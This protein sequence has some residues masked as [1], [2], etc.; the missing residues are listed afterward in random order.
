MTSLPPF[1]DNPWESPD[2]HIETL[3]NGTLLVDANRA[4]DS[5]YPHLVAMWQ[6]AVNRFGHRVYIAERNRDDSDWITLTY[7][8]ADVLSDS[9]AQWLLNKGLGQ[10]K[11]LLVLSAN[12]LEHAVL[13]LA[14]YK[15]RVPMAPVSPNYSLL[16][17]DHARV[18][19]I[20]GK[21]NPGA[22]F[23]QDTQAY[24]AAINA[25]PLENCELIYVDGNTDGANATPYSAL[26]D[27]A[28][29][30]DVAASISKLSGDDVAKYLF[31]S[32]S[33][34]EPKGVINTHG[35][36]TFT[37]AA[38][39]TLI[40]V[41]AENDPPILLDWMPWHHTYGGNQNI[42]RVIN[43]GGSLYID[44]GKPLPGLFAKTLRNIKTVPINSYTT[45]P[46]VYALLV[47]AMSKDTELREHFFEHVQW[48]SYGG[49]DMPQATFDK[50]QALAIAET[51][52]RLTMINALGSTETA[53]VMCI[54]HWS[55]ERMG[56]VG[57]PLPGTVAKLVPV[58]DKY[59]LRIKGP[60]IMPGYLN[61]PSQ[62]AKAFDED[63]F[64]CTGDAVKWANADDPKQGLI[65]AGRV[66]ED[67][68][69]LNGTWVHTGALRTQLLTALSPLVSDLVI[70]GQ[71]KDFL[72][73][74]FWPQEA[75][76]RA[77]L[78]APDTALET[79][80]QE[81]ALTALLQDR[82]ATHNQ[83]HSG[84]STRIHRMIMLLEAPDPDANEISDKRYINQ[85]AV[86]DRR[87]HLVDAL[88]A[89]APSANV[90]VCQTKKK[91]SA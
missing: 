27:T 45:V 87:A 68:K 54:V 4:S 83:Q 8:E 58:G 63:G 53:A 14:C 61:S 37:Q 55:V 18:K 43:N 82:I 71:D 32:G 79:L 25:L 72:S 86:L 52:M 11:P 70:A 77:V 89:E 1:R 22:V 62:T 13:M 85:R 76:I 69:L 34:G 19:A 38:L 26:A 64:F 30:A 67:F 6:S 66:S 57:L 48:C 42:H 9:C 50:F 56:S 47:E 81:P 75:G 41:D 44:S 20:F 73:I 16:S 23:V 46:A 40:H 35:N 84:A 74:L 28:A 80:L 60:Q 59:E 7:A 65:F 33:T 10:T 21:V 2:V 12:S 39:N 51:G 90:I 88:Y 91:E 5:P 24:Q 31:T 78:N 29:T 49:S 3:E 15:A 17:K 36:L